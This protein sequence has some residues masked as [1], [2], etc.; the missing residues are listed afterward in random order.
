MSLWNHA[1]AGIAYLLL[2]LNTLVLVI[3]LYALT[4]LKILIPWQPVQVRLA[5]MLVWIAELWCGINNGIIK[6]VSRPRWHLE[7][8]AELRRDQWYLV[9]ANHQSWADILILQRFFNRRIP[10]LKFFLKQEL[11]R[12]PLLG[13]AWWA[14]DFPFMKRYSRAELE[15]NPELRGK[16]VETTRKACEKF[17]YFP[18]SVMNFFE[19][20]RL[21]RAKQQS[22][23][24]PFRHLLRPRA[25]GTAF[26][27]NAMGGTLKQLLDVTII[28]PPGTPRT[29]SAFLGGAVRD[30]RVII[31]ERA[32]PEWTWQGDYENDPDFRARMQE[33]I[34][35]I[36]EEKDALIEARLQASASST[37]AGDSSRA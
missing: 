4:L 20:T 2:F 30:I 27:L 29:L 23:Q 28:Y 14:L 17:A 33:W 8:D 3:P 6:V 25:G 10:L 15:R 36:W 19:G 32:I 12:V 37:D 22:Q 11:I 34:N 16:D 21:T 13:Q 26:T 18:T 35:G 7:L 24:S 5:R 1:R 31:R 9:T